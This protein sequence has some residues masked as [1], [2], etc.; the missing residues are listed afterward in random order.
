MLCA[1]APVTAEKQRSVAASGEP[2]AESMPPFIQ[3]AGKGVFK[4]NAECLSKLADELKELA[5]QAAGG[6]YN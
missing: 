6:H 3:L 4:L 1:R 5:E 2:H